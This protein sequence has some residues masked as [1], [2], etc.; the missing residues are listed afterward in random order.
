MIFKDFKDV[1]NAIIN[2]TIDYGRK[3]EYFI[4]LTADRDLYLLKRNK[5]TPKTGFENEYSGETVWSASYV[6]CDTAEMFFSALKI[7]YLQG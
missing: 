2:K 6:D 7:P 5:D 1:L 4:M 3:K